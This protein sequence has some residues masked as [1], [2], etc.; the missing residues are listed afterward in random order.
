M[1]RTVRLRRGT[2]TLTEARESLD[3]VLIETNIETLNIKTPQMSVNS[4]SASTIK[5]IPVVF[6][7]ADVLWSPEHPSTGFA[8]NMRTFCMVLSPVSAIMA[9]F[10]I[11]Y[12]KYKCFRASDA[13][14]SIH[15]KLF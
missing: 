12:N 13:F 1:A 5:Q 9:C 8:V 4:L 7:E 2:G 6:G 15:Y 3:E 10:P 14:R 11:H